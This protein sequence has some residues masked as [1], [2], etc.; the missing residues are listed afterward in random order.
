MADGLA[1]IAAIQAVIPH[2][3]NGG[4]F[5]PWFDLTVKQGMRLP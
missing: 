3:G 5:G 1:A 4:S 2:V